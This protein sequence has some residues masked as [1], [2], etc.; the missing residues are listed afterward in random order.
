MKRFKKSFSDEE[1]NFLDQALVEQL[2]IKYKRLR[3]F[4]KVMI[5]G[6]VLFLFMATS[7]MAQ[8]NVNASTQLSIA[9]ARPLVSASVQTGTQFAGTID[10]DVIVDNQVVIPKGTQVMGQ[11]ISAKTAGRAVGQAEILLEL[12]KIKKGDTYIDLRTQPITVTA[13]ESQ[14]RKT[15][16]NVAVGAAAG[17]VFNGGKGAGRGAATMGAVSLLGGDGNITIPKGYNLSFVL[18]EGMTF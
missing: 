18:A 7:L 9:T 12:T 3:V 6:A 11:V 17:A 10:L 5:A 1:R 13:G 15:A 4:I 14:G 2:E 16:R 8:T